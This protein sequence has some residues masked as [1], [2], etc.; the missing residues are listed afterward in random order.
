MHDP[1]ERLSGPDIKRHRFFDPIFELWADIVALKC[2]PCPDPST[3]PVDDSVS[4]YLYPPRGMSV[5]RNSSSLI[6]EG[7]FLAELTRE[8]I[9]SFMEP[10]GHS[11]E[12]STDEFGDHPHGEEQTAEWE[13][14]QVIDYHDESDR[15]SE[16]QALPSTA[17]M[18]FNLDQ[19]VGDLHIRQAHDSGVELSMDNTTGVFPESILRDF[20]HNI[21]FTP[22]QYPSSPRLNSPF[23]LRKQQ[24]STTKHPNRPEWEDWT[25]CSK[26]RPFKLAT[27]SI[28]S[29][30]H[31]FVLPEKITLSLLEAMDNRDRRGTVYHQYSTMQLQKSK[32]DRLT[33]APRKLLKVVARRYGI[34][35]KLHFW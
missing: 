24:S 7:C 1:N 26:D 34:L 33:L 3:S 35:K 28:V 25:G 2:P 15:E 19:E 30:D 10:R 20:H 32:K 23:S 12:L 27:C 6:V 9:E 5:F 14:K 29:P 21:S 11:L 16:L 31:E 18:F 22:H 8:S 17:S 13:T 4:F